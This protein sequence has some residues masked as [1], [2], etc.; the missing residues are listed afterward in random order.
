MLMA[1]ERLDI[2]QREN[3]SSGL[4]IDTGFLEAAAPS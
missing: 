3:K 1:D 2:P 4:L